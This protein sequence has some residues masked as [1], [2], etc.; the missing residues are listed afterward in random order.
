MVKS[1]EAMLFEEQLIKITLFSQEKEGFGKQ[2]RR[3]YCLSIFK[4]MKGTMWNGTI[5]LTVHERKNRTS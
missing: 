2:R 1:L 3:K 5:V 4:Y